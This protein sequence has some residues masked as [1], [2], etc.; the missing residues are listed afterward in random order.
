MRLTDGQR[1][2]EITIRVLNKNH[3]WGED[4]SSDFFA[5]D[6][7]GYEEG[8]NIGI[9]KSVD[10]CIDYANDEARNEYFDP[11]TDESFDLDITDIT[12]EYNR[13]KKLLEEED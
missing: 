2:V 5:A 12:E 8:G 11:D 3:F 1:A 4:L 10:D 13:N 7:L 9:V 6:V